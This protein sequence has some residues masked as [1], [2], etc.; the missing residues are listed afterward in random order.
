MPNTPQLVDIEFAT[1]QLGGNSELL[2][3]MLG[4]FCNEFRP[5]PQTVI[6]ALAQDDKSEAKLKVHTTKGLSGNLGLTALYECSKV[7]DQQIRE[8]TID[9]LQ[10][11]AFDKVMKDTIECIEKLDLT[12]V[13]SAVFSPSAQGN[14]EEQTQ[15]FLQ[16]LKRNEFI[17]DDKLFTY[18]NAL[19]FNEADKST[20]KVLVEELQY[21]KAIDMINQAR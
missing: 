11:E 10:L 21:A 17:D 9:P 7:L 8:D 16:R 4:K 2:A 15:D 12:Q 1:S 20:L 13:A 5:V 18:I 6:N 14:D 3:K 19:P